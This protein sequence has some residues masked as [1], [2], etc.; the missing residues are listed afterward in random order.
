MEKKIKPITIPIV[1]KRLISPKI[2]QKAS[3]NP[4]RDSLPFCLFSQ[5][6]FFFFFLVL[7][8]KEQDKKNSLRDLARH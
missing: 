5:V 3:V 7:N 2:L 8:F 1:S 6:G 4:R